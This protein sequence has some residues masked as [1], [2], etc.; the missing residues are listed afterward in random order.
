M[1]YLNVTDVIRRRRRFSLRTCYRALF[2]FCFRTVL[3]DCRIWPISLSDSYTVVHT[4][5]NIILIIRVTS[6]YDEIQFVIV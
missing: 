5:F 6:R 4:I 1:R 2:L 3:A